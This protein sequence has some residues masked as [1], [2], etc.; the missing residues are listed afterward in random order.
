LFS[1]ISIFHEKE[2][3]TRCFLGTFFSQTYSLVFNRVYENLIYVM[4]RLVGDLDAQAIDFA[5]ASVRIRR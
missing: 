4:V 1:S 2:K 5:L 3:G